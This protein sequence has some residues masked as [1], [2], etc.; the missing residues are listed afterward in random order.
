MRITINLSK[1]DAEHIK[2]CMS[3]YDACGTITI[4][5]DKIKKE[6][7]N[8]EMRKIMH[9]NFKGRYMCNQACCITK[10]KLTRQTNEVTCKNCRIAMKKSGLI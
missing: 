3:H 6:I 5:V 1:N 2:N 4:L 10:E 7:Q 8:K 9:M